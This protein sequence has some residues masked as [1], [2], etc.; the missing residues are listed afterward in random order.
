VINILLWII[1]PLDILLAFYLLAKKPKA[2]KQLMSILDAKF[3]QQQSEIKPKPIEIQSSPK[4]ISDKQ[5]NCIKIAAAIIVIVLIS[6][7]Y[8]FL[9]GVIFLPIWAPILLFF[10][11][12]WKA[13]LIGFAL[14][15]MLITIINDLII[16]RMNVRKPIPFF[17]RSLTNEWIVILGLILGTLFVLFNLNINL[18]NNVSTIILTWSFYPYFCA[19]AFPVVLLSALLT[20]YYLWFLKIIDKVFSKNLF[21]SLYPFV[22]FVLSGFIALIYLNN[23]N[24]SFISNEEAIIFHRNVTIIQMF[25]TALFI[26]L[27]LRLTNYSRTTINGNT[28]ANQKEEKQENLNDIKIDSEEITKLTSTD[29]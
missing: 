21:R 22:F 1:L 24:L 12:G 23:Y 25:L 29:E 13:S 27:V 14:S 28:K 8:L 4:Q 6:I 18:D 26:P 5:R 16:H 3:N 10:T 9:L 2:F 15:M 11:Y 7:G 17:Y 20:N 19:S